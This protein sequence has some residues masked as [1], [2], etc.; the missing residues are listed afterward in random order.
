VDRAALGHVRGDFVGEVDATQVVPPS[1]TPVDH[2]RGDRDM[3]V[4]DEV[5]AK[6][7]AR[8]AD[9]PDLPIVGWWLS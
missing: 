3:Q 7:R 9:A 5:R 4:V 2:H 8:G 6:E 1:I